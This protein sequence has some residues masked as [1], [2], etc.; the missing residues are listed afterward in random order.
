MDDMAFYLFWFIIRPR[1]IAWLARTCRCLRRNSFQRLWYHLDL[2][3]DLPRD[4]V[5]G[6]VRRFFYSHIRDER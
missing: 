2:P 3:M 1:D 6:G 5:G 4:E